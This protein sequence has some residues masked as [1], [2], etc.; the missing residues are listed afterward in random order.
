MKK[1]GI[2]GGGQLGRMLLQASI[3]FNGDFYFMDHSAAPLKSIHTNFFEGSIQSKQE[4]LQFSQ[5]KDVLSIEIENVSV[6]A[7]E[8]IHTNKDQI[9]IPNPHSLNIIKDKGLQKSFYR[10]NG[11]PTSKYALVDDLKTLKERINT[12][13]IQ[14]PFVHK[15]RTG[16][17]DGKGVQIINSE[18][19]LVHAFDAPSVVE[20][21]VKIYKELAIIIVRSLAGE[22]KTYSPVEMIFNPK[23]NLVEYVASPAVIDKKAADNVK[24]IAMSLVEKLNFHGLLAIEFFL[25]NE[26]EILINECAPRTHNSGH[27]TIEA[28]YSSQFEQ[29]AR[30]L[31]DLPLGNTEMMHPNAIMFNL[32]GEPGY[33]GKAKYVNLDL[34]YQ[35][36]AAKVHLYGKEITKP[37]RKMGHVTMVGDDK[38]RLF[39][40]AQ[41]LNHQIKVICHE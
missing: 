23:A 18:E 6:A 8:E 1:I 27:W 3:P 12:G 4:V 5:N 13:E 17:Y 11:L 40:E 32:L 14:Y 20:E 10:D 7:L 39:E 35:H 24:S 2:L 16:G 28:C 21:K 37:Y 38:A 22:T 25:T 36:P 29:H 9:V 15:T 41:K 30:V 31:L 19:D 34:A 33:Q 26:G